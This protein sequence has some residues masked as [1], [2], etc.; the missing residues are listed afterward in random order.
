MTTPLAQPEA[1][2]SGTL[3]EN[4]SEV[5]ESRTTDSTQFEDDEIPP[6]EMIWTKPPALLPGPENHPFFTALWANEL[7]KHPTQPHSLEEWVAGS[8]QVSLDFG[9]TDFGPLP[10]DPSGSILVYPFIPAPTLYML[11]TTPDHEAN[12]MSAGIGFDVASS[13]PTSTPGLSN[14]STIVDSSPDPLESTSSGAN[15]KM[16]QNLPEET[17]R[18]KQLTSADLEVP[19]SNDRPEALCHSTYMRAVLNE[20]TS[21][22]AVVLNGQLWVSG[23]KN[24]NHWRRNQWVVDVR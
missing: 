3:R 7:P 21:E 10:R 1:Q 12:R 17:D 23:N 13:P 9:S 15:D 24:G 11:P 5:D 6:L 14:S 22:P 20:N 16:S 19:A 18:G 2:N 8:T 4:A